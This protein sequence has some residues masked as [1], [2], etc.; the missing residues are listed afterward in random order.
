M[1]AVQTIQPIINGSA[2]PRMTLEL[3]KELEFEQKARYIWSY[4]VSLGFA[5][6][7]EEVDRRVFEPSPKKD[8]WKYNDITPENADEL[9]VEVRKEF[10][11][12]HNRMMARTADLHFELGKK[13]YEAQ[14]ELGFGGLVELS[15][16]RMCGYIKQCGSWND[17]KASDV[18]DMVRK[19]HALAPRK[20]YGDN[21]PNT[22]KLTHTW[23]SLQGCSYVMMEYDFIGPEELE[24]V[25]EF[26]NT[27]WAPKARSVKADSVRYEVTEH[28]N[29]YFGI[30]LI[31]WWD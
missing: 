25:K 19:L 27:H 24:R 9:Y 20:N 8:A 14:K 4:I 22:G 31:M 10:F 13:I 17:F 3:F 29:N 2:N 26:Y 12:H 28:G 6:E 16:E 11:N 5:Q 1:E 23:K 30:E 15:S 21:N 7:F 18:S